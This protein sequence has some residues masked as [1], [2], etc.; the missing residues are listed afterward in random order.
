MAMRNVFSTPEYRQD[1]LLEEWLTSC[2]Q[3]NLLSALKKHWKTFVLCVYGNSHDAAKEERLGKK[4]LF[5]PMEYFLCQ[6][7]P[8]VVFEE[9]Q[10]KN[11][12]SQL[13]GKV[14]KTGEPT[15][16]CRDCANDPTCVLCID[17]FQNGA[18][19][20]HRYKMNTSGGGGYCD[21][22]DQ[23]AW[24]SH[25]FCDLHSPK[26]ASQDERNAIE[27][28]P[29]DLTDRAS[30]LFMATLRY[31]VELLTWSQCDNL[32][33]DLQPEGELSDTYITM[34][35]NDEVHTYDQVI[36]TLQRAVKNCTAQQA[37]EFATLVDREG[38]ATVYSGCFASC[39]QCRTIIDQSTSRHGSKPLKVQ[40]MHTVVV[41]HQ[42]FC[43]KLMVWLQKMIEKSDGLRR[44]FCLLSMKPQEDGQSLM[45]KLL[46]HDTQLWK[47]ARILSHQLLMAGVL[48]DQE[49]KK[50]FA[51]IFT[52]WYPNVM[53]DFAR[54]DHD[55]DVCVASLSVQIYTVPS[56]ARMLVTDHDLLNVILVPFLEACQEK[57]NA[58]GVLSL[59]KAERNPSFKRACFMLYDLKYALICK[60]GPDEWNDKLRD[61]FLRGHESFLRLLK[62]MQGMDEVKRQTGMHLEY[63]PEWEGAFNLQMRVDD[64]IASFTEWC[65][66]DRTVFIEAYKKAAQMLL[67]CRDTTQKSEQ[68]TV[69]G[70]TVKCIKYD[71]QSQPVSIHL[72]LTRYLAGLLVNMGKFD[73]Q[74]GC[75]EL[76]VK[77][78]DPVRMI[79]PPLRVQVMIA[80]SQ[81]GLWRRNGYALLNQIYFYHNVKCR[82][83]MYDKDIMMLQIGASVLE[84]N[85]FLI[86][87]LNRYGLLV[88]IKPEYDVPTGQDDN[89]RQTIM[90]AEEFLNLVLIILGERYVPGLG[91]VTRED[92]LKREIIHLLCIS[93]MSNSEL[94]KHLPDNTNM[95]AGIE[96]AIH[97]VANFRKPAS[98]IGTAGSGKFELKKECYKEFNP[99]FYHFC[100]TDQSQAEE[101]QIKRKKEEKSESHALPPPVPPRFTS[102]FERISNLLQC[103]VMVH[104]LS[105]ILQRSVATRSRSWSETQLDRILHLIGLALHEQRRNIQDGHHGFDFIGK[106]MRGEPNLMQLL[107]SLV[108]DP[109]NISHDSTKDLLSW[110]LKKFVEV[111]QMTSSAEAQSPFEQVSSF[112][113]E[114]NEAAKKRKARL[115]AKRKE[116]IIAKISQMQ[117]NFIRDNADLFESTDAD[118]SLTRGT[119]EMDISESA[120]HETPVAL[121]KYRST[122]CSIGITKATCI[123]CQEEQEISHNSRA[124]VLAGFVQRSTVMSQCKSKEFPDGEN[125]DPLF[126]SS[127]LFVG[128]FTNSCGHTMHADCWQSFFQAILVKERRRLSRI[129][130]SLSYNI[131]QLE[132]L[133]PLCESL[134]NTVIP[135]IPALHSLVSDSDISSVDL[136]FGDW[137]DGLQKTVEKST[138]Q[139]K[140][141]SK[142]DPFPLLPCPLSSIT[143][144]MA[145]SVASNFQLLWHYVSNTS[146]GRFSESL[147]EMMKKFA[148]DV[149]SF[150]LSVDPD[151]INSR[152]PIMAW[153][154][155]AYTIINLEQYLRDEMKPLFGTSPSRNVDCINALVKF[156]A[157]CGQVMPQEVIKK[158]CLRLLSGLLTGGLEKSKDPQCILDIDLFHYLTAV[159]MALPSLY[160]EGATSSSLPLNSLNNQYILQLVLTAHV[161]QAMLLY[162]K[163]TESEDQADMEMESDV[164][165]IALMSIYTEIRRKAG[166]LPPSNSDPLPWQLSRH[167]NDAVL[168]F[169]RCATVLYHNLTGVPIP[170]RL[171]DWTEEM[172]PFCSYLSLPSNFSELFLN[173]G[174]LLDGL[175]NQWCISDILRSR[176]SS[177][178]S[179]SLVSYPLPVNHLID[180]PNDYSQLINQISSFTCP[181]S[182]GNDSQLPTMCLVCGVVVCSQSYCCQTE[183]KDT[184]VGAATEHTLR[185][186]AGVGILLRVRECQ[187]VLLAGTKGCFIPAPYVDSY[188]ETDQGLRRG[189]PLHLCKDSY[190]NLQKMWFTHCI[191]ETVAHNIESHM[192]LMSIHWQ[193]L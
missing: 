91:Q 52:K 4:F 97:A 172:E 88:W 24:T 131:V 154:T 61:S 188:G 10:A 29:V 156:A 22:G 111:R 54:D 147:E 47:V 101:T 11:M 26:E 46:L 118:T 23:E 166:C 183:V 125:F 109:K 31:I 95:E 122:P 42:T 108:A 113:K 127:D 99:Y 112:S 140:I 21:C 9:L 130:H 85:E 133:C 40:V 82:Q 83:E 56:L 7:D 30:A 167:I 6:K 15:Y 36:K 129:P 65:S 116:K 44:L 94:S 89:V 170:A 149:Y 49:C 50:Q 100:R 63:E 162:D 141:A 120:H 27:T 51:V 121:G 193:H 64:V 12:P 115:A 189:N 79:E 159:T 178:T 155:C 70:H 45:E 38:R 185:C 80:Q 182:N 142:D 106:A 60:P 19:K 68:Q 138:K 148:K 173:Q 59:N 53:H 86:H 179:Q 150:G 184:K 1:R 161:V 176:L 14:F 84:S 34:L 35:F 165:S 75:P 28:L 132:Y 48:M 58:H 62:I 137:L 163:P 55:H 13:C 37:R 144:L 190:K 20:N 104:I 102:Q 139:D 114:E 168:P 87:L 77:N 157:V 192:N 67:E 71:V 174:D 153:N 177:A 126:T 3:G 181:S 180:L 73:L 110:I 76:S 164:E 18:H 17:C 93:P 92:T 69:C 124:M 43:L 145:D 128:T 25:P 146:G 143:K 136:G 151:D 81:A 8:E 66:T 105:L 57:R 169:L 39:E 123:L 41:A 2:K 171:Q 5:R 187:I 117:Q 33:S 175:L 191:P 158:H 96:D 186:G 74:F 32:P 160:T 134:S 107:E 152:I 135:L 98:T 90:L 119:S 103:D 72:P 78:L 16:S